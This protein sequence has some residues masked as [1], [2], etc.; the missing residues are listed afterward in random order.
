MSYP[1]L[2]PIQ[3]LLEIMA[4]LRDPA[5]GC[6][7]DL[8][9]TFET[10]APYTLEEAYE[11]DHAI[12]TGDMESLCDEL[13]DLLLQVVF[14]AQMAEEAGHFAFADVAG[15][16]CD[17]LV[18]RHPHIFGDPERGGERER[19]RTAE[20]QTRSWEE[21]KAR[22]RASRDQSRGRVSDPFEGIPEALPALARALKLH[23]RASRLSLS[24]PSLELGAEVEAEPALRFDL[25]G[26]ESA[27]D[28]LVDEALCVAPDNPGKDSQTQRMLGQ[29]LV[30]CVA[31]ART[32]GVDPEDALRAAN[33]EFEARIGRVLARS[34]HA[35]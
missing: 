31:A 25:S 35:H 32:L 2:S 14:H 20:D 17:K 5:D 4:R 11:V 15:A 33:F 21:S 29:L 23:K 19:F 1:K 13:G 10:I 24:E 22:E 18:R 3:R 7:W 27:L 30:H 12:R 28:A 26:F 34:H 6:P 8:E 16:I 9:Q